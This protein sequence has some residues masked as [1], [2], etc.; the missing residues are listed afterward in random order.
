MTAESGSSLPCRF[1]VACDRHEFGGVACAE[2]MAS[3]YLVLYSLTLAVRCR[4]HCRQQSIGTRTRILTSA[5]SNGV[6]WRWRSKYR[7][8]VLSSETR[9]VPITSTRQTNP[10]LR[11]GNFFQ[12]SRSIIE[13]VS[14][15]QIYP[16]SSNFAAR[17]F[18]DLISVTSTPANGVNISRGG[19]L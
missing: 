10:S 19:E 5:I 2:S 4:I 8:S 11:T 12:R 13:L 18:V 17:S 14:L 1:C 16:K 6:V 7:M 3:E 15:I 9:F